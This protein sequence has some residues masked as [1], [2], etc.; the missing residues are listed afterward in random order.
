MEKRL[1]LWFLFAAG[2]VTGLFLIGGLTSHSVE[3]AIRSE[4]TSK[5]T[6]APAPAH[7]STSPS[8]LD[9]EV[10]EAASSNSVIQDL[11]RSIRVAL[12]TGDSASLNPAFA[13]RVRDLIE[14]DPRSAANFALSLEAGPAR[15]E[16]LRRVAQYWTAQDCV[17]ARQWAEQLSV[18]G[19]R[20]AALTDVCF[21]VAQADPRL[22]TQLADQYGLGKLPGETLENL[23]QQ[24]AER[25]LTTAI[26]WVE[27]RPGDEQKNHML[28]RVAMVVAETS[29]AEAAQMVV[30]QISEGD[31]RTEAVVSIVYQW[32]RRDLPGASAWV[33]A[34]PEG[35]LRERVSNELKGIEQYSQTP[36]RA[37][38]LGPHLSE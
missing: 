2:L 37:S 32:A 38:D 14:K 29:P 27:G 11:I 19:E 36:S 3:E 12:K 15:E 28:M 9:S 30:S 21:Q 8:L 7:V 31:V 13:R 34:F 6:K 24:W 5:Q 33:D 26:E 1:L 17:S 22:A 23:V 20:N 4:V 16:V 18:P 35:P 10:R 25:D